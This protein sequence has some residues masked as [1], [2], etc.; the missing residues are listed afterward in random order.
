MKTTQG[1]DGSNRS[2]RHLGTV[3]RVAGLLAMAAFAV[4]PDANAATALPNVDC[5]ATSVTVVRAL[6]VTTSPLSYT[7]SISSL[8]RAAAA[9]PDPMVS[10]F[11][12]SYYDQIPGAAGY[13]Y[14]LQRDFRNRDDQRYW[15]AIPVIDEQP[16]VTTPV[17]YLS[18]LPPLGGVRFPQ[19]IRFGASTLY[20]FAEAD[21]ALW[22]V[23]SNG[24]AG[25]WVGYSNIISALAAVPL[26][27]L[28]SSTN[29]TTLSNIL[30]SRPA[31]DSNVLAQDETCVLIVDGN[32]A[33]LD[34]AA[35][36]T[37]WDPRPS[38]PACIGP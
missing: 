27:F 8:F 5:Q 28:L 32:N 7:G 33:P 38:C 9:D 17:G 21:T 16:A 19:E 31:D 6:P 2:K 13:Y 23:G 35:H 34:F 25:L 37:E 11:T 14:V 3:G 30:S 20:A 22:P 29:Y 4:A 18:N 12:Q 10:Q 24:P 36:I 15:V 1:T 26:P